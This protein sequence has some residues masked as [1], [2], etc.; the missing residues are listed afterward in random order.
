MGCKHNAG[1]SRDVMADSHLSLALEEISHP[2]R[3]TARNNALFFCFSTTY[4]RSLLLSHPNG[5]LKRGL[6]SLAVFIRWFIKICLAVNWLEK[7]SPMETHQCLLE[8]LQLWRQRYALLALPHS[9]G[10]RRDR[11]MAGV[12]AWPVTRCCS[13]LSVSYWASD[14]GG[15]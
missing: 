8:L 10:R 5:E 11:S 1:Y 4:H 14:C 2:D 15:E 9:G 6:G 13:A 3:L 7:P 12:A